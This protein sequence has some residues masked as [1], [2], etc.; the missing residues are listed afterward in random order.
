ML[1]S[2]LLAYGLWS[3]AMW[4]G[5]PRDPRVFLLDNE[6]FGLGF[7]PGDPWNPD[8]FEAAMKANGLDVVRSDHKTNDDYDFNSTSWYTRNWSLSIYISSD[9]KEKDATVSDI[10]ISC[11]RPSKEDSFYS[12]YKSSLNYAKRKS[13]ILES[14]KSYSNEDEATEWVLEQFALLAK[15]NVPL[16]RTSEGI[17]RGSSLREIKKTYGEPQDYT[18]SEVIRLHTYDYLSN[19][20]LVTFFTANNI[21]T[22]ICLAPGYQ[23]MSSMEKHIWWDK[24]T[25]TKGERAVKLKELER[26]VLEGR[27]EQQPSEASGAKK[28]PR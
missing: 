7:R 28:Y 8:A 24:M 20:L 25:M 14:R 13:I 2:I 1:I 23:D 9:T 11:M 21:A 26:D 17:G 10:T 4:Y 12:D 16:V 19:G 3:F 18:E 27:K 6:D 5:P 22:M 15:A